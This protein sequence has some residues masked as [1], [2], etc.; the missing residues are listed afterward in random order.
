MT[1]ETQTV[2]AGDLQVKLEAPRWVWDRS[3]YPLKV[4]Y[5][6][7]GD[8]PVEMM[9]PFQCPYI[10]QVEDVSTGIVPE[11]ERAV[12]YGCTTELRPPIPLGPGKSLRVT[13]KA[14]IGG[15]PKGKY[16]IPA[17]VLPVHVEYRNP[18]E[19]PPSQQ[20]LEEAHPAPQE[21]RFEIR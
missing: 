4:T 10:W 13:N 18:T 11:P 19:A 14:I 15:F 2:R 16:R 20:G 9:D 7:V 21:V 6:N 8:A 12:N 5:T 3:L 17:K 1:A